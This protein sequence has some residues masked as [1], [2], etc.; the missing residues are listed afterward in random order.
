MGLRANSRGRVAVGIE[1]LAAF[2][3]RDLEAAAAAGDAVLV[4]VSTWGA[5][6]PP[7]NAVSVLS[8]WLRVDAARSTDSSLPSSASARA[9]TPSS[10]RRRSAPTGSWRRPVPSGSTRSGSATTAVKS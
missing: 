10:T 4:L 8:S 1:D 9:R 3:P 5:G 7:D 2:A 6:E